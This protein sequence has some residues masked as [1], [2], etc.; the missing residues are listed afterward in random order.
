MASRELAATEICTHVGMAFGAVDDL[1]VAARGTVTH[2][3][4]DIR[5][6]SVAVAARQGGARA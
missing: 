6:R 5:E 2:V 1:G 3:G 4:I